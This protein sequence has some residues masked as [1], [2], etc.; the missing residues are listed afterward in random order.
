M[1]SAI[2][3]A[4]RALSSADP[5]TALKFVALRSDPAALALRGIAMAQLGE[6]SHA[7]FLL[8]R[9]ARRFGPRDP[10]ARARCTVA[11]AE[12]A[13]AQR[14]FSGAARGLPQAIALLVKRGDTANAAF[15]RLVQ[16]RRWLLLGK[17]E[18]AERALE[19]LAAA[20]TPPRLA[21]LFHL[22]VA[23]LSM[24]RLDGAGA[25]RAL[26]RAQAAA[27]R[28]G[29]APLRREVERAKRELEEPI[30]RAREGEAV[31]ITDGG[32]PVAELRP[33]EKRPRRVTPADVA[34]VK[35]HR[36]PRL[37]KTI[38]WATLVREMRDEMARLRANRPTVKP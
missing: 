6:L 29:I 21:A 11:Q 38:D 20:Q 19:R 13:L 7:K 15:A 2:S 23:D 10:V 36:A 1:D 9:A 8:R 16:V 27:A 28:A 5:L 34:W 31:V 14:D 17:V 35:A 26:H 24:K 4:A 25:E 37:A 18:R 12:V 32:D 30:A 22:A 33:I 3:T